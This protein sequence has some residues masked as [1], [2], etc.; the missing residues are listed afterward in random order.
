MPDKGINDT[1]RFMRSYL[2]VSLTG[3][4][5]AWTLYAKDCKVKTKVAVFPYPLMDRDAQRITK[6]INLAAAIDTCFT[7][8]DGYRALEGFTSPENVAV[9]EARMKLGQ[10]RDLVN[11]GKYK[12]A[13]VLLKEVV[14]TLTKYY[15]ITSMG[16]EL[17]NALLYLGM[18]EVL[19]GE[20]ED[21]VKHFLLAMRLDPTID[22]SILNPPDEVNDVFEQAQME[23][24]NTSVTGA[25]Y[26]ES[27]PSGAL[28]YVDGSFKGQTPLEVKGLKPGK[29][30]LSLLMLGWVRVS[31]T[32]SIQPG[33][34]VHVGEIPLKETPKLSIFQ[35]IL[36]NLK[37]GKAQAYTDAMGF[38]PA[39]MWIL[40][41][42]KGNKVELIGY[43]LARRT[44]A[45][46]AGSLSKRPVVD[47]RRLLK[48]LLAAMRTK[49]PSPVEGKTSNSILKKWWFWT[50]V[51]AVVVGGITTGVVLGT[52]TSKVPTGFEKNGNGAII[53]EF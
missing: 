46:I 42:A 32:V 48:G 49:L 41:G 31:K 2:F 9:E 53:I 45:R 21:A 23:E 5:L 35:S 18:C 14:K 52:R 34:V 43:D 40:V 16:P 3:L 24:V 7:P 47:G 25:I 1:I 4:L 26:V 44:F 33:S 39:K 17:P 50:I 6:T 38:I 19:S 12:D 29:H 22:I 8:V 11:Q 27:R 51:G 13:L 30:I 10:A 37:A 15:A 20:S 36:K 28:V